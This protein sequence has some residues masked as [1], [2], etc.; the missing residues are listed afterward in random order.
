MK[1]DLG[2]IDDAGQ[3]E[4]CLSEGASRVLPICIDGRL[5][6]RNF[7]GVGHYGHRLAQTLERHA[8]PPM[9][10][11]AAVPE[12][13]QSGAAAR[14]GRY[15]RAYL[16]GV[17]S[18]VRSRADKP[19]Y[20]ER[21]I[22]QDIFRQAYL[23]FKFHG[24]LMRLQ[25][26]GAAGIMHWTYPLP[27]YLEGWR[28]IYTVH[29]IIPIDRPDLSSINPVRMERLL[30]AIMARADHLVTV[31]EVV[32]QEL[33]ARFG[34]APDTVTACH[35]V[36]DLDARRGEVSRDPN[37]HFLFCGA[38]E[39]RKNLARLARAY[40]ASGSNRPLIIVGQDGWRSDEVRREI[41]SHPGIR[42]MP[43]QSRESLSDLIRGARALLF[44]SLAEGFGLPV[45]EALVLGTPVMA[46]D[47]PTLREVAGDAALFVDPFDEA[48]MSR[49]IMRL[50][51]DDILCER[52]ARLGDVK[53]VAYQ[54]RA[55]HERLQAIYA[56]VGE[57]R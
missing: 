31:S 25:V 33:V 44:P 36:A 29:D 52:L 41:G 38:V 51:G 42:F 40:V 23:H 11:D 2:M 35:Q 21:L 10:L 27:L 6:D 54:S 34:C 17:R 56:A 55:Y 16:P 4:R 49:A 57:N 22:G 8:V 3:S 47:I 48:E 12:W 43:L 53:A 19:G 26:P 13:D 9:R 39:P 20:A 7:T 50:D 24:R 28:N 1:K 46:S 5:L 14:M 15:L 30:R 37:A 32:R 18:L 45:A